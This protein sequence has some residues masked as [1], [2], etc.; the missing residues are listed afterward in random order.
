MDSGLR[1]D[2]TQGMAEIESVHERQEWFADAR[3]APRAMRVRWHSDEGLIVLSLWQGSSCTGT[4]RLPV[5]D[6]ARLIG[7]LA[8][9]LADAAR[10][11]GAETT[12]APKKWSDTF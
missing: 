1:E 9:S 6:A 7:A 3:G 2:H 4:F 10:R 12:S 5:Q 11:P 8:D